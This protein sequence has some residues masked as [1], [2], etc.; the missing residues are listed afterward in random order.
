MTDIRCLPLAARCVLAWLAPVPAATA[1]APAVALSGERRVAFNDGWR[2][3]KGDAA[4]AERPDFN[5]SSLWQVPYEPGT[6]KRLPGRAGSR[7]RRR[8]SIRPARRRRS[9]L[10]TA[11]IFPVP[12]T[13]KCTRLSAMGQR[14]PLVLDPHRHE[15]KVLAIGMDGLAVGRQPRR[16]RRS[17]P[18]GSEFLAAGRRGPFR[19]S[20][21]VLRL[22][23]A[24]L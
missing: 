13:A 11:R 2:F 20:A 9:P 10:S 3:F 22:E 18:G 7:W 14:L 24:P 21:L 23:P 19:A 15:G 8:K 4:G 5:G 17:P 1:S 6:K 12:V 16:A